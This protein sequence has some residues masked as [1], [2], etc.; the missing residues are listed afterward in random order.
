MTVTEKK[1]GV[2][3]DENKPRYDLIPHAALREVA[4]VL[5]MGA[6][7]YS[8]DNWKRVDGLRQR[9][10][11][12]LMRHT[13][14]WRSGERIDPESGRSHLAHVICNAMFLMWADEEGL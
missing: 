9:Y 13:E 11:A 14:A 8:D 10:T 5:T 3:Y 7:K 2:K 4:D 1:Q 6:A 12:A